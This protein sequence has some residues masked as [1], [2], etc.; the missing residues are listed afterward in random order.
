M[1][2]QVELLGLS[3]ASLCYQAARPSAEEFALKHR[4]GELYTAHS[5]YGS[6][7]LHVKLRQG[8]AVIS[9][10]RVLS[11]ACGVALGAALTSKNGRS[12]RSRTYL[13]KG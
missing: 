1:T 7:W 5:Y 8:G 9:R 12:E 4:I 6:Q 2:K 10:Q 13:K 3:R 11:D